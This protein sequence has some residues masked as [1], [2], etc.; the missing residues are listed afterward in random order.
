MTHLTINTTKGNDNQRLQQV[1]RTFDKISDR[2]CLPLAPAD[3]GAG[4]EMEIYLC[5]MRRLRDVPNSRLEIKIL[6][7]LQ[8]AADIMN[9]DVAE[10]TVTLVNC[11][12]RA[13]RLAFPALFL[14]R[15]DAALMRDPTGCGA[16]NAALVSLRRHWDSLG[17]DRWAGVT[18]KHDR[19]AQPNWIKTEIW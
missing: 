2:I 1:T 5:F 11:G 17:E 19:L 3:T 13:P 9:D 8:F 16:A 6:H 15:A 12:L 14:E 7:A 18:R 10:V 4:S